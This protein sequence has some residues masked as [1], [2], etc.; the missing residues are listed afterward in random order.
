MSER[1]ISL[2]RF[3]RLPII[4]AARG[5]AIVA[6]VIYHF[7]WNLSFLELIPVDLRDFPLWIWFGHSIAASFLALVGVGLVLA[8]GRGFGRERFLRR[9][10]LVAGAAALVTA[11]TYLVF[12]DQFIFFGI[13][14][15]IA[16]A[17]LLA[18]P[19]LRWPW[20]VAAVAAVAVLALPLVFKAD[21]LSSPWLV[22]LGLGTR[23]PST[24]DF[25]PVF[26]W[27]ACVLA[28]M[29]MAKLWQP[30]ASAAPATPGGFMR[31]LGWM[32]RNS[33]AIYLI[34]QPVLYGGL[35]VLASAIL[36][37]VD[38]ETRGF[39]L[40]CQQQC[41]STGGDALTCSN[42]C[43][44]MLGGLKREGLWQRVLVDMPDVTVKL[45]ID[46]VTRQC[47]AP[48]AP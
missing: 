34:H 40:S 9:L 11:G 27:F 1:P 41:Q 35:A 43:G 38:R 8:H 15:H 26:P 13:L 30:A 46:E 16:L 17:S 31:A 2:P 37:P 29:A 44:C 19:F 21:A 32:G 22:W 7:G 33:L 48:K 6:M 25:V 36:P 12:P 28:G 3:A 4:D 20:M 10:A 39:L 18:L 42:F 14:H 24:N 23:V 5:V 47:T 45:R